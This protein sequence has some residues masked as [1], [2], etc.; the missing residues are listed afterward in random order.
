MQGSSLTA[1]CNRVTSQ[2]GASR[3]ELH[4]T[5]LQS[6]P[7]STACAAGDY[8]RFLLTGLHPEP[9]QDITPLMTPRQ[10]APERPAGRR[11]ERPPRVVSIFHKTEKKSDPLQQAASRLVFPSCFALVR[12]RHYA[13][14]GQDRRRLSSC[15]L[16]EGYKPHPVKPFVLNLLARSNYP[17][18]KSTQSRHAPPGGRRRVS[19][20]QRFTALTVRHVA[21]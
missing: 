5:M 16:A 7:S 13:E 19:T 17:R 6:Y 2:H 3:L 18:S 21:V 9:R 15:K 11:E 4:N 1:R 10:R 20:C 14:P 8:A 12:M